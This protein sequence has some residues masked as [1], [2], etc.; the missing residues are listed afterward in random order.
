MCMQSH[1]NLFLFFF[2]FFF[3]FFLERGKNT[4]LIHGQN[5]NLAAHPSFPTPPFIPSFF[6][7]SP[8]EGGN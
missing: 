3:F 8:H 5:E 2:H 7:L 4:K 1:I 6:F